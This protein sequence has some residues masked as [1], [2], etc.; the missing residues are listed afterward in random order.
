[1][2]K[3]LWILVGLNAIALIVLIIYYYADTSDRNADAIESGW[4]YVL[5]IVGLL[6]LL[7]GALPLRYGHSTF[8]QVVGGFF[9]ALPLVI[10]LGI[11]ISNNLPS[12]KKEKTE[13]ETYY[14]D[15][16]QIAIASAIENNNTILL[17][18]L[19]KEQ[20]LNI[21]G[22][23]VWG[24]PGL[25]YLQFAV[26]LKSNPE[27]IRI[28][29]ANGSDPTPALDEAT[30]YLPPDIIADFLAAGAN[31]NVHSLIDGYP[32]LFRTIGKSNKRENDIAILL[33]VSG[34]NVNAKRENGFTPVMFAAYEAGTNVEWN[35]TWRVVRYLLEDSNADY[36]YTTSDGY[37]LTNIIEKIIVDAQA[38][39]ITMPLDFDKVELLLKQHN[40]D[41][42]PAMEN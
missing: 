16:K 10:G 7:L 26:R 23:E 41:T 2:L 11:L 24:W 27:L 8:S 33:I 20:N 40:K 17:K 37:N 38:E 42:M 39:K 29:I 15:K 3:I 1:M 13:A 22:I 18:E 32:V 14:K 31:P 21:Q 12:F 35:D 19:I 25:N 30:Q 9:A 36:N 4:F 34:A 28:L 5:V 6:V